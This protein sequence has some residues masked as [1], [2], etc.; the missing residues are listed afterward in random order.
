MAVVSIQW[1]K[2]SQ[3]VGSPLTLIVHGCVHRSGCV[4]LGVTLLGTILSMMLTEPQLQPYINLKVIC[5]AEGH[6]EDYSITAS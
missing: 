3:R 1:F 2:D 5:R 4:G 6:L